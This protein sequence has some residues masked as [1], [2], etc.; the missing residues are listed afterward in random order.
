[1][2][3]VL[4]DSVTRAAEHASRYPHATVVAE[5]DALLYDV[6]TWPVTDALPPGRCLPTASELAQARETTVTEAQRM[7]DHIAA[8][9]MTAAREFIASGVQPNFTVEQ[10]P[11]SRYK[12]NPS[13]SEATE[14]RLTKPSLQA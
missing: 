1:M 14:R 11:S 3:A 8:T 2:L 4:A 5:A 7:L 10:V 12:T 13:R 9:K 6:L